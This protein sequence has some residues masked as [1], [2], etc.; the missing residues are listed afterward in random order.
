[1]D[2][3]GENA[4]LEFLFNLIRRAEVHNVIA[5]ASEIQRREAV[6]DAAREDAW[7]IGARGKAD[8]F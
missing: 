7:S 3:R 1:M 4:A 6:Q 2:V 8:G 5:V